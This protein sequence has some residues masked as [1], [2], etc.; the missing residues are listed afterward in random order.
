MLYIFIYDYIRIIDE[1][2]LDKYELFRYNVDK[3]KEGA[4]KM[5]RA[6]LT[7]QDEMN[8]KIIAENINSLLNRKN[9]KQVDLSNGTKIPRSTLT[10]Y[11]KGTSLPTPGN[12]QKMADFFGVLKS[13]IDP[14]FKDAN[15]NSNHN[16]QIP[17]WATYEDVIDLE[18]MLN[19]N[20]N[21]AFGGEELTEEDKER[22]K[23]VLSGIYFEKLGKKRNDLS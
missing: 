12:V 7:P 14:R 11:V 20:V 10:G 4:I 6:K 5:A 15:S 13:Q 21:M 1:I 9:L 2:Y 22:I 18:K 8:K 3:L 16:I 17:N 19:S 23:N